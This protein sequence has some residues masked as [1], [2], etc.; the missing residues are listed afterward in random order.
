ME[1]M[2]FNAFVDIDKEIDL[3]ISGTQ[4]IPNEIDAEVIAMQIVDFFN[5]IG[6]SIEFFMPV[7]H[8]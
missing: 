6:E 5:K 8:Q 1:F 2:I 3:S 7:N 4:C